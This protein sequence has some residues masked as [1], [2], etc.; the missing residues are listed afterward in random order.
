LY[1]PELPRDPFTG[2][3]FI[4]V[5]MRDDFILYSVGLDRQDNGGKAEAEQ[6][7]VFGTVQQ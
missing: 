2:K 7:I 6:D 1:L 5:P 3:P 4:Y